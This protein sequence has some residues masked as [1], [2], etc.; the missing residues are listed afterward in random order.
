MV[1][2]SGGGV[3]VGGARVV[4][5]LHRSRDSSHW[6]AKQSKYAGFYLL[7]D[8]QYLKIKGTVHFFDISSLGSVHVFDHF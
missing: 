7:Q 4:V 2:G 8:L 1:G 3:V 5:G 6:A